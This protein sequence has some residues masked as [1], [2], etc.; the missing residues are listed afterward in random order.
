LSRSSVLQ[1]QFDDLEQ[2]R[3]SAALGMWVFLA[4]EVLFFGGLFLGFA[5]Y[6]LT[7]LEG[8]REA[9]HHLELWMGAANT[10]ILLG[11]SLTVA[12]AVHAAE[13][14]L[15]RRSAGYLA[16]TIVLGLAF[17]GVKFTE[18][19]HEYQEGL[20]PFLSFTYES[21]LAV[22]VKLYFTF[23]FVM[24]GLHALHM[25]IGIGVFAVIF[26]QAWRRRYSALYHN[27]VEIAGLY[28]HFV[29]VVWIFLFPV[30][31]LLR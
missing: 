24:T 23:Y 28:W 18:Y 10:A 8:F 9:T 27:P 5:I 31:Y 14:G 2:Q 20:V 19:Y 1:H 29:D 17:L 7:Y 30:L 4:T 13:H 16:A 21:P 3:E 11:S 15:S 6:R 22:Q 12:L 25:V 26:T